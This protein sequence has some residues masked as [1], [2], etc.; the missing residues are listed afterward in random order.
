VT[1]EDL[2]RVAASRLQPWQRTHRLGAPRR[3]G[4]GACHAGAHRR[5]RRSRVRSRRTGR[6]EPPHGLAPV[7]KLRN[8]V[9]LIVRRLP[10]IPAGVLRVVVLSNTVVFGDGALDVT[11]DEPVWRYTSLD[12]PFRAGE[13]AQA[14]EQ[15][16]Q[17]LA[18]MKPSP[19]PAVPDD[20]EARLRL[21]LRDLLGASPTP[22]PSSPTPVVVAAVGDLDETAALRLLEAAF[23]TLPAPRPLP[24]APLQV[25]KTAA[26]I[27][28]PG[29]A[30]AQLGY[31]VPAA[32]TSS[33]RPT[34]GASFSTS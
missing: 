29:L 33:R 20:P 12:I 30:Q 13:L 19:T 4:R 15:A 10:R 1:A 8:G 32:G 17:A 21:A 18:A 26:T 31:A 27:H 28:L 11:P 34:L 16:R 14:V 3:A 9:G 24:P 25:T 2:Q 7:R 22:L 6:K 23:S 5:R